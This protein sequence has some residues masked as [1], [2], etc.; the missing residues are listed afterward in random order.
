MDGG[1]VLRWRKTRS[2][3]S[4]PKIGTR[5]GSLSARALFRILTHLDPDSESG[6]GGGGV[7][8]PITGSL[9]FRG[10]ILPTLVFLFHFSAPNIPN[11][12]LWCG[13]YLEREWL[14][15]LSFLSALSEGLCNHTNKVVITGAAGHADVGVIS[16]VSS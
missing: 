4:L 3:V 13:S 12:L 5:A 14:L 15:G 11:I 7:G 16:A 10:S 2:R 8:G 6:Y 9:V 1:A